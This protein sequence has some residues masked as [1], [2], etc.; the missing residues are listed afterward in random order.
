MCLDKL[1]DLAWKRGRVGDSLKI[2]KTIK[3]RE[4]Q[5]HERATRAVCVSL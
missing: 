3:Q 4:I 5:V 2:I 1:S